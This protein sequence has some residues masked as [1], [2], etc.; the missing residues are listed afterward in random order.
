MLAQSTYD[1]NAA[2]QTM[3]QARAYTQVQA[4]KFRNLLDPYTTHDAY[5]RFLSEAN[6]QA[7]TETV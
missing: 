5:M 1:M 6:N 2:R 7:T 3:R 4:Q